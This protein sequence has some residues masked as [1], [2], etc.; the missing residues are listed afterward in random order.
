MVSSFGLGFARA[1]DHAEFCFFVRHEKTS[2][3]GRGG[4]PGWLSPHVPSGRLKQ[5]LDISLDTL[6]LRELDGFFDQA[7]VGLIRARQLE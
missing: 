5:P 4:Q 6:P 1:G 3:A 7:L 2:R